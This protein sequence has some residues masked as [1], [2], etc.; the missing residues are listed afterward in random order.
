MRSISD[1]ATEM[2]A[3]PQWV[4][5]YV[6]REGTR[7]TKPPIN[8]H[9]SPARPLEE[10]LAS[11]TNARTWGTYSQALRMSRYYAG[12][13]FMFSERDPY[14]GVDLD[15]C[16]NVETG[17]IATWA[18]NV[19]SLFG[20]YTEISPSGTGLHI[21]I[22]ANLLTT[23]EHLGRSDI[24]HKQGHFEVYDARRYFTW[25]GTPL[26]GTPQ[27]IE[28]RQDELTY[29]YRVIF[30][31]KPQSP[32][33]ET[34]NTPAS[35]T[36]LADEW[37]IERASMM[38]GNGPKFARLWRGDA[39]DYT[40]PDGSIDHSRADQALLGILAYW[41]GRDPARMEALFARSGLYRPDRWRA[42]S[43]GGLTYGQ[44][45]I[46]QAIANCYTT[47]DPAWAEAHRY[48]PSTKKKHLPETP[49]SAKEQKGG[50]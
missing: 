31:Q 41:T 30:P 23:I 5:W 27:S 43:R 45:S 4:C 20:S 8:P 47:Y 11:P 40:R 1:A 32:Q 42:A 26:P 37:I 44:T 16:R 6:K 34:L 35:L 25:S 36:N 19:V 9:V 12:I 17:E 10:R 46:R 28:A 38:R 18:M 50:N 22:K 49:V 3:I 48:Q 15:K 29:F 7:S 39:S 21:I 13:G 24:H 33:H 2:Q 14:C